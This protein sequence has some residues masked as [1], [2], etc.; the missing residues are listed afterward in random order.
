[1]DACRIL[2]HK[3]SLIICESFMKKVASVTVPFFVSTV[4]FMVVVGAAVI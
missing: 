2:K 1:M 4:A 3:L